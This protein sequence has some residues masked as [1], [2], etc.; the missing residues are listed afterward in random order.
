MKEIILPLGQKI[1]VSEKYHWA[2]NV[3]GFISRMP[4]RIDDSW[5]ENY[6]R[7]MNTLLGKK[8]FY[9]ITLDV[10]SIDADG[11]G[12]YEGGEFD[13]DFLRLI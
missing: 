13:S 3:T 11:D 2:Q 6:Y 5:I 9:W 4:V 1:K 7:D 8:R 10:P 12:P